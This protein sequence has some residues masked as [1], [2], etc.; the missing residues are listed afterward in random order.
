M[1]LLPAPPKK[2]TAQHSNTILTAYVLLG[3]ACVVRERILTLSPGSSEEGGHLAASS[4]F[5]L[6]LKD[7]SCRYIYACVVV[8]FVCMYLH[9][10]WPLNVGG[11]ISTCAC[12]LWMFGHVRKYFR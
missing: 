1:D 5:D 2:E 8:K 3:V 10:Y 12:I 7:A 9:I 6:R 11:N 4:L